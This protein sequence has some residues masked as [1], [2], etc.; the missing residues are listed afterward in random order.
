ME[1]FIIYVIIYLLVYP[2]VYLCI[3]NINNIFCS[4]FIILLILM[5]IGTCGF[6]T[7]KFFIT[8]NKL[9]CILPGVLTILSVLCL[10]GV[11]F[12]MQNA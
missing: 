10:V 7:Y 6:F 3:Y 8:Q 1:Y 11:V 5:L 12:L 4:S 2:I 9:D